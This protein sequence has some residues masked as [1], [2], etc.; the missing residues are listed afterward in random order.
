MR[1]IGHALRQDLTALP[2][3]VWL[4]AAGSFVNRF[5]SFVVPFLVLYLASRGYSAAQGALAV[6][7]YAAGKIAAGPAGGALT[8]RLG[9]KKTTVLSMFSS[10][11]A[12]LALG[13]ASGFGLIV[14]LACVTGLTS[15]LY[16]PSTSAIMAR[17]VDGPR[18]ATAFSVYQLGV[19]AGT[20]AG[21]AV[22]GLVAEH[23]FRLLFAADAA[24]SLAW[25]LIACLALREPP[26]EASERTA[27]PPQ[28]RRTVL[29]DHRLLQIA[30]VTLLVNVVLFQAQTTLPLWVHD[31]GLSSGRYGLLLGLNSG[32]VMALQLPATRLITRARPKAVIAVSSL[33]VGAGFALFSVA[34]AMPALAGAVAVWSLGELVQWPVAAT[35]TTSLAPP[36]MTGRYAGTRSTAYGLALL[37]APLAG[38]ALYR[39]DPVVLWLACAAVGAVAAVITTW[40]WRARLRPDRREVRKVSVLSGRLLHGARPSR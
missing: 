39:L 8:D 15:E 29:A 6:A 16:R 38:T 7:A 31:Q 37:V 4:V 26:P 23:S 32:L 34:H 25:G 1:M 11:A 24:T 3:Q 28:L 30:V 19:S 10:G 13:L 36:G 21:P 12:T 14:A 17:E 18:R 40:P 5:G 33:V 20:A 9:A 2:G 27:P 22:G 35:Y